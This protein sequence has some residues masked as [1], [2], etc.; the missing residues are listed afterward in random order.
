M[1][2][3]ET[4]PKPVVAAING[5]ALGGGLE[6]SISC[7]ARVCTPESALGLPELKIGLIPGWGGTQRLPRLCGVKNAV[8]IMLTSRQV[9]G[10]EAHSLGIVD[11]CVPKEKLLSR[12][13]EIALE[14][15][16]QKRERRVSLFLNDKLEPLDEIKKIFAGYA[17]I[18]QKTPPDVPHS[19]ACLNSIYY[20]VTENGVLGLQREFEEFLK[21][22]TAKSS[23]SLIHYF[24]A[25]RA[26]SKVPEIENVKPK[27]LAKMSIIGGGFMGS[28]IIVSCLLAGYKVILKEANEKFMKDGVNRVECK[29]NLT[30]NFSN[31]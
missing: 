28:G 25:E 17:N 3:I 8:D 27:P 23:K 2:K 21:C 30:L 14:I 4:G 18:G 16:E 11:D 29:L 19:Q 10:K 26:I 7:N 9:K 22:A 12:A 24:F 5:Y 20:G 6:I 31:S 15:A 1:N 13:C